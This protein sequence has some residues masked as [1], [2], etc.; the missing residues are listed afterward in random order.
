MI[1]TANEYIAIAESDSPLGPFT[2]KEETKLSGD[3]KQIDPF[4]FFDDDGKIY[5]IYVRFDGGNKLFI[6]EMKPDLSDLIM[7]TRRYCIE[8]DAG[9]W[10]DTDNS[11]W[12]VCE[13]PT[14]LKMDNKYYLLYSSNDFRSIDYA[15]GYAISNSLTGGWE[16]YDNNLLVDRHMIN[17]NGPGHGDL[18]TDKEGNLKYV[19]HYHANDSTVH[20]RKTGIINVMI[21]SDGNDGNVISFNPDTFREFL[22]KR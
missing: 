20:Q 1:Y 15:V 17:H 7:E 5:L 16:K 14:V 13:G 9:T 10:E 19:L 21:E 8:S 6:A 4:V 22:L 3:T 18:F 2:Q 12:R 11:E